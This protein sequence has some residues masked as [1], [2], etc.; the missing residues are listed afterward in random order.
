MTQL[1]DSKSFQYFADFNEIS[2]VRDCARGVQM[3]P[4][5]LSVL[6]DW[7]EGWKPKENPVRIF[8]YGSGMST[9]WFAMTFP[10]VLVVSVEGEREWGASIDVIN[11][12]Y[13]LRNLVSIKEDQ[14]D[15][16]HRGADQKIAQSINLNYIEQ[17][18]KQPWPFNLI[19]NDGA[20]RERVGDFV[21]KNI[22]KLLVK[23]GLYLRHDYEMAVNNGWNYLH[24]VQPKKEL[25]YEEFCAEHPEYTM[26][27]FPGNGRWGYKME[28]GGVWRR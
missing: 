26:V 12:R 25:G 8:E 19:I 6:T 27:T 22:D 18:A 14:E 13:G 23:D 24:D 28:A 11:Q 15:P 4:L 21:L 16:T 9:A 3:S 10:H 2:G 5:F 7:I 1:A 20:E 17:V